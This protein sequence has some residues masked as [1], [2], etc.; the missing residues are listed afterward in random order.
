MGIAFG[1]LLNEFFQCE[2]GAYS[3]ITEDE[4]KKSQVTFVGPEQA[5]AETFFGD[6]LYGHNGSIKEISGRNLDPEFSFRLH[7]TGEKIKLTVSYKTNRSNEL[8][9]YLRK[10]TFKPTAG[11]YWCIFQRGGE[12]WLGSFSQWLLNAIQSG[13]ISTTPRAKILEQETDDYQQ[14]LNTAQPQQIVSASLQWKRNPKIAATALAK[15]GRACE[16]YPEYPTFLSRG[17]G[18]MFIEA[19]NPP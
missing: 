8:R 18:L 13:A 19:G 15:Y 14:I 2:R 3:L 5:L 12:I 4:F 6:R 1:T 7:P 9:Y 11:E 16:I 17:T 10:D